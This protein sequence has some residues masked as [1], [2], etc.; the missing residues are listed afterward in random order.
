M[1]KFKYSMQNILEIKM[2]LE[3]QAK[4]EFSIANRKYQTEKDRLDELV[5]KR[6]GYETRL[7]ES[8]CGEL[9]IRDINNL[10]KDINSIK[11]AI[12]TQ[13]SNV[14]KAEDELEIKRYALNELMK[15]RKTHEKLRE[16]KFDEFQKEE[17]DN[18]SKE[19][20]QL[21]SFTYNN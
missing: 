16:K 4:N 13:L 20:D 3:T 11:S 18:E 19:I 6:V 7:K 1:A 8:L 14:K 17:R 2:K 9:N 15:E 12:R 10:K 21:V 5:L